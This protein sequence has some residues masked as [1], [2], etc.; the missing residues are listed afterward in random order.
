MHPGED[1]SSAPE[2]RKLLASLPEQLP[3]HAED[4]VQRV[5]VAIEIEHRSQA[6]RSATLNVASLPRTCPR[7]TLPRPDRFLD[8]GGRTSTAIWLYVVHW[9]AVM[10]GVP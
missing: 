8:R 6:R 4:V 2:S 9:N 1:A 3:G 5:A 7:Q 10:S